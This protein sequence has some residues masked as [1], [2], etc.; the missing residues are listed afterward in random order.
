[1]QPTILVAC[2]S[3]TADRTAIGFGLT[4]A[5]LL[6]ARLDAV[7]IQPP[8]G[9]S[10]RLAGIEID[11]RDDPARALAELE[12]ALGSEPRAHLR[13]L[14]ASSPAAGLQ[15]CI[16]AERPVLTVLGSAHR[17]AHGQVRLGGTA[18][19]VLHGASGAVAI[20]PRGRGDGRIDSIAVG[21][22]PTAECRRALGAGA[23]LARAAGVPLRVTTVLRRSPDPA[24]AAAFA[25]RLA[26]EGATRPGATA[27]EILRAAIVSA[28]HGLPPTEFEA[29]YPP[30]GRLVVEPRVLVGDPADALLRA[31]A[32]AGMLVL[33]SRAYGPHGVVLPGGAALAV[34]DG[35]RCPVVLVPRV[36]LPA[37]AA[38]F[39]TAVA[40]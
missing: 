5:R 16:A 6:G 18:E 19:R 23:A 25:L 34:L 1:M 29:P 28:A 17:A 39:A 15:R 3:A 22:L 12:A 24:D 35:A 26:P 31:S 2:D 30:A 9:E 8:D 4:L 21:L 40:G 37:R 11:E 20:V 27:G 32:R 33:G 13:V 14:R 36:Q 10:E 7:S 38:T